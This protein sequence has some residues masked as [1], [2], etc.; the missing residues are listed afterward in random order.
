MQLSWCMLLIENM[1]TDTTFTGTSL[2][3][4]WLLSFWQLWYA[5]VTHIY[6]E[7]SYTK[8]VVP[9][10]LQR[11]PHLGINPKVH[12]KFPQNSNLVPVSYSPMRVEGKVCHL[13]CT[14]SGLNQR[15]QIDRTGEKGDVSEVLPR[16]LQ[17]RE[18]TEKIP[19]RLMGSA[20][21]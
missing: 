14:N 6:S 12:Q 3:L 13:P 7:T 15:F 4:T 21:C 2:F 19:E 9:R 5:T 11:I 8:S 18:E 20:Q 16:I 17:H 1:T 10:N